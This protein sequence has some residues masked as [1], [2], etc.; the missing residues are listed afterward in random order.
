MTPGARH[1]AAS[2][3]AA[4]IGGRVSLEAIG[5][6]CPEESRGLPIASVSIVIASS[7]W[8]ADVEL[9]GTRILTAAAVT[10]AQTGSPVTT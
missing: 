3:L 4:R 6:A 7:A 8:L 9:S 5:S 2:R 10:A 1:S